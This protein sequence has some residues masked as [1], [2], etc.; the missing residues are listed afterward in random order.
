MFSGVLCRLRYHKIATV[1]RPI[2]ISAPIIP[3]TTSPTEVED[4]DIGIA[5]LEDEEGT[6]VVVCMVSAGT[7]IETFATLYGVNVNEHHR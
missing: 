4:G 2:V 7:N 6:E 5:V 1:R 3:P